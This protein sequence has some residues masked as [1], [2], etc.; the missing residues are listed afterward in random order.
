MFLKIYRC[1]IN[2][3][4][5]ILDCEDSLLPEYS[6]MKNFYFWD[7]FRIR[8]LILFHDI[9]YKISLNSIPLGNIDE[10]YKFITKGNTF[11]SE[12]I[13]INII[14]DAMFPIWLTPEI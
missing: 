12:E 10:K 2:P 13:L 8:D 9:V 1:K 3:K 7:W 14:G 6:F 5:W 4:I 11:K